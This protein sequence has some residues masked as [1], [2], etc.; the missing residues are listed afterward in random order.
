MNLLNYRILAVCYFCKHFTIERNMNSEEEYCK[1]YRS[2]Q[3]SKFGTCD[4]FEKE[5]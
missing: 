4:S 5:V 2:Y 1:K 3:I